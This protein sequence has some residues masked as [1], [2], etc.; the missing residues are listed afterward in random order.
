MSNICSKMFQACYK[1]YL[2]MSNAFTWYANY[3]SIADIKRGVGI[4]VALEAK[5]FKKLAYN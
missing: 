1:K 5:Y 4:L 3:Y 2:L